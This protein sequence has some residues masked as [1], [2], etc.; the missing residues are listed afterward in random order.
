LAEDVNRIR[1]FVLALVRR[2]R[3]L[4]GIRV[5]ARAALL[6]LLTLLCMVAASAVRVDRAS[7]TLVVVGLAGLG[8]WVAVALPLLLEWRRSGDALRQA[9]AVEALRP[10]LRGRLVT[11]VGHPDGPEGGESPAL[12]AAVV[13][14]AAAAVSGLAPRDVHTARPALRWV[15]AA[16]VLWA[17]GLPILLFLSGGPGP[18]IAFWFGGS[19]ARAEGAGVAMEAPED[20]A[21]VGDL[22]IRYQYPDYTGLEPK[23]V[24]N[25]TGDVQ[26]PPGTVVQVTAR[27]AEVVEAAGLVAY[28][29]ALEATLGPQGRTVTGRFAIEAGEGVYR[30][31][32]YRGGESERSRDFSIVGQEDLPPDVMLDAG[33]SDVLEVA[34]D[35]AIP[36]VWQARDDYGIRKV[37]L[38][39]DGRELDRVLSRPETRRAEV[40]DTETVTP[41]ALGLAPGARVRL[42]VVAWDNDTV[43]GSKRGV[44]REV[45]VVVLGASGLDRR[46]AERRDQLLDEMIPILARHLTDPWP[47]G[48][49]SGV[50]AEWGQVVAARYQPFADA[51]EEVWAGLT[52]DSHDRGV[53]QRIVDTG[54]DLIRYTQVSFLPGSEEAAQTEAVAMSAT[55]R[56]DA[57]TALEDGVLAF[58]R[59]QRLAALRQIVG[60]ADDLVE[61]GER[62][63]E[64][65]AQ[66]DP[67]PQELLA[68]LDALERLNTLVAERTE[69]LNAGGLKEFLE[70]RIDEGAK[71]MDEIREA[72]ADG[73]TEE[74]RELMSR[75]GELNEEMGRGIREQL[76]RQKR[77]AEEAEDEA[78][79]LLEELG[80][81]AE[82]QEQLQTDVRS[83]REE[84]PASA[85]R[86]AAVWKKLDG[87]AAA[88]SASAIDYAEGVEAAGRQFY[89]VERAAGGR[90]AAQRIVGAVAAR[91][92]RGA[93]AALE[94][95]ASAWGFARYAL[96]VEQSRRGVLQG[97]GRRELSQLREQIDEMLK[98]L[99]RP[100]GGQPQGSPEA[101]QKQRELQDRQKELDNRMTQAQQQAQGVEQQLPVRPNGMQEA[102]EDAGERMDQAAD[103]LGGGELMQA[104]G[105]QGVASQR[106]R[107]AIRALEQAL[108]G[109][110][111]GGA[112]GAPQ[113]SAGDQ[114]GEGTPPESISMEIPGRE[115]F[116]TPEEYRR[117]LRE[118]M[119]ED[120]P[121]EYRAMKKRYYEE[122]VH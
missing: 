62:L 22:M 37:G 117:A 76:E 121:Q 42:S 5:A 80:E 3:L 48:E 118:G 32:L 11:A 82:A 107:D 40:G 100:S 7:A 39:I 14:R 67:D 83:V 21:R 66:P 41:R 13:Q 85:D 25:S 78:E 105:S 61:M 4:L 50:M 2:E 116:R 33:S 46:A 71:L 36:L 112:G 93:T 27:S 63:A 23:V 59:L 73:R 94:Q 122:L 28:E 81:I 106:I 57:I 91:D 79:K 68:Q 20:L 120:V 89:E 111:Q 90:D 97:P 113:D 96:D 43:A 65:L 72:L 18:L 19:T 51:V 109:S 75:L 38:A 8:G 92:V 70:T 58:H 29:D 87:L 60:S 1:S 119:E 56:D 6:A 95:G 24:P 9:R 64:M 30:L 35:E 53:A 104:E 103:D 88:H 49:T 69:K 44:S 74:A 54:R 31:V 47:P 108:E 17:L 34:A 84:D 101:Q 52:T 55:M 102:L 10:V 114:T 98:L 45:E 110:Q 15:G 99:R 86:M 12:F 115:E 26:A 77:R 16:S